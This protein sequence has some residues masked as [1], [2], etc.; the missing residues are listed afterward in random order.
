MTYDQNNI[1]ARIIRGEIPAVKVLEDEHVIAFMDIMPWS[2]G[3]TLVIPKAP[4]V[5]L[6][7]AEPDTLAALIRQLQVV[8][9]AVQHAFN[10][11]GLRVVQ[12]NASAAGQTVFHLH[13]HIVPCYE[14]VP[15]H[16][17][18]AQMADIAVLTDHAARIR[19]ALS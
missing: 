11:D 13:F 12:N 19:K 6:L 14:G 10:P 1:F 4:S 7:D 9:K 16:L 5:G 2:K 17:G 3:H 18:D 8:A 15:L